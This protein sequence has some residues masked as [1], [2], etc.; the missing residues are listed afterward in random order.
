MTIDTRA[1]M[2]ARVATFT[3][4]TPWCSY[5]LPGAGSVI[6][7]TG[8]GG[9]GAT[10]EGGVHKSS[11][12]HTQKLRLEFRYIGRRWGGRLVNGSGK[13]ALII[14]TVASSRH[15][16]PAGINWLYCAGLHP[17]SMVVRTMRP[18]ANRYIRPRYIE[19]DDDYNHNQHNDNNDNDRDKK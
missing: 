15:T 10:G 4:N 12:S 17:R 8:E 9:V 3:L 7:T 11:L 2:C 5:Y 14:A 6:G 1:R 19:D 18:S 16:S 13:S